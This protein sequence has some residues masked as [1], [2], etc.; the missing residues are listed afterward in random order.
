MKHE[1]ALINPTGRIVDKAEKE[2]VVS[3]LARKSAMGIHGY[4]IY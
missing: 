1:H 4:K 3:I 2:I